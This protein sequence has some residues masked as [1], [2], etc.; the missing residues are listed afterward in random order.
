MFLAGSKSM[1][2][3]I[4]KAETLIERE[5]AERCFIAEN[6]SSPKVSIARATV[7]PGTTT[8]EH[9]LKGIDEIYLIVKGNGRVKIGDLE[10]SDLQTGD[11]V[12]IPSGTPQQITN[13]GETDLVFYCVCTP[14]FTRNCYRNER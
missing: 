4:V 8:E 2:P 11:T 5:T 6:W 7:K 12:F 1:E 13:V 3:R 10:P 9:R 14:R